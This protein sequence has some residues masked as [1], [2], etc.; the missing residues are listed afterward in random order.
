[1][2]RFAAVN[3]GFR[4]MRARMT[5]LFALL[6]AILMFIAGTAVQE[7]EMRRAE[8]RVAETLNLAIELTGREIEEE[9]NENLLLTEIPLEARG[10]ITVGD[11]VLVIVDV[12]GQVL[13]RSRPD[14]PS[15]PVVGNKWRYRTLAKGDQILIV[16]RDW[17]QIQGEIR[18]VGMVLWLL[19]CLTVPGTAVVAWFIVGQTLSPLHKLAEQAENASIESLQVR[20]HS[21]SSD[22]EMR[23]LTTTLNSLLSRLEKEAQARGRF[24][25]AASHELRTP[26]QVLLGEVDVARSRTR[27]VDEHEAVLAQVQDHTERLAQLVSDL[28]QLNALEMKQ[29]QA[30]AEPLNLK[31]WVERAAQQQEIAAY[32]QGQDLEVDIA[33]APITAPPLHLEMLLRNLMENAIKYGTRK[34]EIRVTLKVMPGTAIFRVWNACDLDPRA[35][36]DAWFEAFFR[37]DASRSSQTGGNGLGLAICR[38]VC[39]ANNWKIKLA[40]RDGGV[41]ATVEFPLSSYE[42]GLAAESA[43]SSVAYRDKVHHDGA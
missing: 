39:A 35:D 19:G 2:N 27:S 21:P 20:L 40:A 33:D 42:T 17:K 43:E 31:F 4:S 37:P 14:A 18:E 41:L 12:N 22:A 29:S 15:W 28:L 25:A 38:S 34:S 26:I 1:M 30:L 8:R 36:L 7:R 24:Y 6:V 5:A 11:I 32:A 9:H 3:V 23:Y 10:E 16:A 13:W